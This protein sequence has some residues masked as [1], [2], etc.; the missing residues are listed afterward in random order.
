M[1][2]IAVHHDVFLVAFQG[3]TDQYIFNG[4]EN[5]ILG[6]L[7]QMHGQNGIEF[8]KRFDKSKSSFKT[9]NKATVKMLF[10]YDTHTT[11]QLQKINFIK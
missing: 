7:I 5:E 11:V 8:L 1:A 6:D 10:S 3:V 4:N 2:T 9:L